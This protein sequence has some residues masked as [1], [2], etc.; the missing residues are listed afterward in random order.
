MSVY[1]D[2]DEQK[3]FACRVIADHAR[4][5]AF[6]IAD[7]ILPGNEGRNYVLRKIMRRAIY[8]GRENLG[9]NDLF[10]YKVCDFVV[11]QM[12]T[13]FP[14]LETQLDFIGKMVR[15]EEERFGNT[16]KIGLEKLR[17]T[18]ENYFKEFR[19]VSREPVSERA[20]DVWTVDITYEDLNGGGKTRRAFWREKFFKNKNVEFNESYDSDSELFLSKLAYEVENPL[21]IG[22]LV[23]DLA[24]L[25]DTFGVPKDLILVSMRNEGFDIDERTFDEFFD[26]AIA[27]LQEN[28]QI[29]KTK[30]SEKINPIYV[31]LQRT[32]VRSEFRGYEVTSLENAK[33]AALIKNDERVDEL[34]EGDEGLI[35]LDET[36]FYAESGGQVGDTGNLISANVNVK[37]FDCFAPMGGI[38]LHKA[39]IE[40]GSLKVGDAVAAVVDVEKRDAT[41]RN[42]TATHLVHAALR[43]VLGTHVKQAGSVVAPNFLRF[44]FSHYQALSD[45][46]IVEIENLVE[47]Y[48]LQNEPVTTDVMPIEDAMRLGAM[49]LFG[50]KYGANVRVLS[51]GTGEFSRELCGGTHVARTG[52]IGSFKIIA[53]E[54]VASGVR[55]IRAITGFDAFA[56]FRED[57]KLIEK[58]LSALRTQRDNLPSAIEKLQEE[59]KKT[60]REVDDLRMKIALGA[61][62]NGSN[63]DETREIAGVKVLAKTVEN[64]DSSAMRNLSDT[65]LSKLK[66]GVVVLGMKTE[67]KVSFI[68]RVSE[69]VKSR[70]PAGQIIKEIAPIVGGKGGGKPD[71]AEGGGNLP[72]KLGEALMASYQVIEKLLSK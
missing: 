24:K 40:R 54:A 44:D 49:A 14:E 20:D 32:S 4:A 72:E 57:E 46:E 19:K 18:F 27:E 62:G 64:L 2:F 3:Q 12:N 11:G 42:H 7:G 52:D 59:L 38:I 30:Q 67:N 17:E 6:A 70:V 25:Y 39:K 26:K 65:L 69:D 58:S 13:A 10:F 53:D 21:H 5:T 16:L 71:M 56:R 37:V 68:V 63:E 45:V 36:P 43:E 61:V 41:R 23:A 50:E 22:Q 35:V 66:S 47:R 34:R 15:L 55:R 31:G 28:L 48:V 8:Q 51:V 60:K 29:G 1:K 33:V 9:F